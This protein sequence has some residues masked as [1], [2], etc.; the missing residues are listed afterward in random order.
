MTVDI[1]ELLPFYRAQ[2]EHLEKHYG[3]G[4]RPSWVSTDISILKAKIKFYENLL[5]EDE[6]DE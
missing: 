4:T 6:S 2:V 3:T 1:D 5:K